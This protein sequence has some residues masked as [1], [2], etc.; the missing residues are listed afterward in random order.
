M[1]GSK[2]NSLKNTPRKR[3]QK[4]TKIQNASN[5]KLKLRTPIE[6]IAYKTLQQKSNIQFYALDPKVSA[7][8]PVPVTQ[9]EEEYPTGRRSRRVQNFR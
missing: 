5:R 6:K 3:I 9:D 7:Q 4:L 8:P 1:I 2:R